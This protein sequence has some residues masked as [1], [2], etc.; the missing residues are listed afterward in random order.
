MSFKSLGLSHD[1]LSAIDKIGFDKPTAIQ[2]ETIPLAID[3]HDLIASAQ[4]GSGKTAAFI[5]PALNMLTIKDN[6]NYPDARVLVLTPTRELALQ[7]SKM[8]ALYAHFMPWIKVAT[9]VGGVS[10]RIQIRALSR[11]VDIIIATPGRLIDQA[12]NGK[13][14]LNSIKLLILDE[15]DRMLDMGFIDDIN[16]IV[17]RI[18]KEHQTLLFSATL[19]REVEELSSKMLKNPIRISL[20]NSKQKHDH[21]TQKLLYADNMTH[22]IKILEYILKDTALDQ[23]IVF[24]STKRGAD[25]LSDLLIKNGFS[26]GALHG[27][28]NQKQ[29]TNTISKLQ[30]GQLQILVATDVAARGIDIEHISHAVNFDL[31]MQAEDYIHRIG[32]TGR[33]GKQG[34][35]LTIAIHNEFNKIK[36]IERFIGQKIITEIISGLEP[37]EKL[38]INKRPQQP[39]RNHTKRD[40]DQS[41]NQ[42]MNLNNKI[43]NNRIKQSK[44]INKSYQKNNSTLTK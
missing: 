30:R 35:A 20:T 44:F 24:T 32:R 37:K 31:P 3:G 10:Y 33:A 39:K 1:I 26:V 40:N 41:N 4:T 15:A 28:M 14:K 38:I 23:A 12:Q 7:I 5:L 43:K 16:N 2:K 6:K 29:R 36:N 18:P 21:I 11:K 8:T 25:T 27:D 17:S 34:T 19:G 22:K 42:K 9:I 13:L